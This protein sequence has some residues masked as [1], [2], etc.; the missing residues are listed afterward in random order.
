MYEREKREILENALYE[1]LYA[2]KMIA[3]GR[4][5][6]YLYYLEIMEEKCRNGMTNDEIDAV[7]MR[8]DN[9]AKKK[10]RHGANK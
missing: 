4:I 3:A 8:A 9:A 10:V 5:D 1:N 6:E 7:T 2:Q